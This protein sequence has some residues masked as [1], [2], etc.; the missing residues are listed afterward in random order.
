MVDGKRGA[1]T[2]FIAKYTLARAL[3]FTLPLLAA[4]IALQQLIALISHQMPRSMRLLWLLPAELLYSALMLW[5]YCRA[6]RYFERRDVAELARDGA[7]R[8][9]AA[10]IV[11]GAALFSVVFALLALGGHVRHAGLGSFTAL[12]TQ[13]AVSI[14]AAVGEE[15]IFRGSI[16]RIAEERLGTAAALVISAVL[17][18]LMHGANAGATPVSTAAIA[19]EAGVLLGIAYTA[20]RSLWLT[21][22]LHFGWN[23]TEGGIF[24]TTVSGGQTHGLIDTALA[25]PPLVTG[26]AFGPEASIIAVAVCLTAAAA[27]G[28]WSVRKGRWRQWSAQRPDVASSLN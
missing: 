17:F 14:A 25:G 7:G 22:G 26:G 12:P 20:S 13:A 10:G 9:A 5:L 18:G 3:V 6:V 4:L 11:L 24:G 15:L 2:R 27:I 8:R 21:I 19:L 28:R 23:F 16:F 1:F